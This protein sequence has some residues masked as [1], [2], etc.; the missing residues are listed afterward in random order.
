MTLTDKMIESLNENLL[1]MRSDTRE[2][3][4]SHSET[5]TLIQTDLDEHLSKHKK[6]SSLL[7]ECLKE[8][9]EWRESS[10]SRLLEKLTDWKKNFETSNEKNFEAFFKF[11]DEMLKAEMKTHHDNDDKMENL[12]KLLTERRV[13]EKSMEKYLVDTMN[14][15]NK[16]FFAF[17]ED[18]EE[19]FKSYNTKIEEVTESMKSKANVQTDKISQIKK[20]LNDIEELSKDGEKSQKRLID[21]KDEISENL[22]VAKKF[23]TDNATI[24]ENCLLKVASNDSDRT[25][26]CEII[27]SN[28]QAARETFK[29]HSETAQSQF[30]LHSNGLVIFQ[31]YS[32]NQLNAIN[33]SLINHSELSLAK[34]Q[35]QSDQ[36]TKFINESAS[37]TI[38]KIQEVKSVVQQSLHPLVNDA[39]IKLN[40]N[41][42][43]I[44]NELNEFQG[45]EVFTYKP[46]GETPARKDYKYNKQLPTTSPHERIIRKFRLEQ[47]LSESLLHDS[48]LI[49]VRIFF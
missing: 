44:D 36:V 38:I 46:S 21:L 16:K 8:Q 35:E 15:Q 24:V 6:F 19:K 47:G 26:K 18:M 40:E 7:S 33:D 48:S 10:N 5:S 37:S 49:E 23:K 45:A 9:K 17:C 20:L 39:V 1:K 2:M 32:Q 29:S 13:A 41:F 14:D 3:T 28:I 22:P 34:Q 43:K 11:V 30:T 25:E 4:R 12:T 27:D 31:T 42:I